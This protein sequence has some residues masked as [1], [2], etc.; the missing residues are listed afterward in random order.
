M[1]DQY[2]LRVRGRVLGP[3]DHEKL[4]SLAQRGQLS[5][6]HEV[7]TDGVSWSRATAF[8]DFF[9]APALP[10][11]LAA[12]ANEV[13]Q[14]AGS[15]EICILPAKD[16]VQHVTNGPPHVGDQKW[17]YISN[18]VQCGPV[19]FSALRVLVGTGQVRADDQV[20]TDGMPAW[21]TAIQV[22]GLFR[23]PNEVPQVGA[24]G[25]VSGGPT[26]LLPEM[27]CRV[28]VEARSW[29][30]FIASLGFL[31]S[32]LQVLL[33][34]FSLVRGA[35]ARQTSVVAGGIFLLLH[36]LLF[37]VGA[38]VL[39][40]YASRLGGLR[41]SRESPILEKALESLRS[42]WIFASI[43]LV[44]LLVFIGV[45]LIGAISAGMTPEWWQ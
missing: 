7:S 9:A 15:E 27:L 18:G 44:V 36:A 42:F 24:A 39:S 43:Y 21:I 32:F 26:Q 16:P 19:D 30:L 29:V 38:A 3:Y 11:K 14:P 41:Y 6:M 2:Y 17:H 37:L 13:D 12:S 22:P 1:S 23:S 40:S 34:I 33:G 20:W 35:Q 8:P 25:N 5:R 45:I 28:A 31:Y 4:R 10:V